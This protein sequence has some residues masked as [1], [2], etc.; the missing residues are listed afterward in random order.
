MTEYAKRDVKELGNYYTT[1][2]SAL[3]KFDMPRNTKAVVA[4]ELAWRDR[5]ID[6]LRC[7]LDNASTKKF[8]KRYKF[9]GLQL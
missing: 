9:A 1:H 5:E 4:E 7:E 2:L 8:T 3:A 6:R